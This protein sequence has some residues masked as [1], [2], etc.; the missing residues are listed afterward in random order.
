MSTNVLAAQKIYLNPGELVVAEE[1]ALV[2]TV[3][4][5][6]VA[7][8]LFSPRLRVGAICHAVLPRGKANLP[9]KFVD[10]SVAYMMKYFRQRYVEPDEIVAKLFGGSDMFTLIDPDSKDRT[11]GAQNIRTALDSLRIAGLEP[12]ALDV[13]GRQG[14]KLIFYT[15]TGEVFIKRVSRDKVEQPSPKGL[16]C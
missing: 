11:I 6:C 13:G 1:P 8:T 12:A 15:H 9:S 16:V 7:V 5:S 3:L 14:R 2:T 4:G 10:Q